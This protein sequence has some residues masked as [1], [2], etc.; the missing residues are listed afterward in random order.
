MYMYNDLKI[1]RRIEN[2][3]NDSMVSKVQHGST[4]RDV[5]GVSFH[6]FLSQGAL[7]RDAFERI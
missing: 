1:G 7:A 2:V 3:W 5:F 6:H 4:E